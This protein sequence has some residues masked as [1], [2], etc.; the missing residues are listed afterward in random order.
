ME[1]ALPGAFDPRCHC[2]HEQKN[3]LGSP[4]NPHRYTSI[5]NPRP[6]RPELRNALVI[7]MSVD[8]LSLRRLRAFPRL[9]GS[10][11]EP[12]KSMVWSAQ[13][14]PAILAVIV[15]HKELGS[16]AGAFR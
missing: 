15:E 5:I 4:R 10:G 8:L 7:A 2:V 9:S 6:M 11:H 3:Y 12:S 1:P 13:R 14:L 16:R